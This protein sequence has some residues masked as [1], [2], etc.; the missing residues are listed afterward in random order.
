MRIDVLSV[1]RRPPAWV[2]DATADYAKRLGRRLP[3][4]FRHVAPGADGLAVAARR[5]DEARRVLKALPRDAHLVALDARGRAFDSEG[6]AAHLDTWRSR[7]AQVVL[8]VGGADG[9]APS[10]LEAAA[11]RWSL[12]PL[13]LPHLLV[14]VVVAEQLYRALTILEGHPYHR[15]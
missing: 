1:C 8:A 15:G 4:A 13:T 6:F 12:S 7:H 3:L 2:R 14:Q 5:E 10:L 9:F 11:E